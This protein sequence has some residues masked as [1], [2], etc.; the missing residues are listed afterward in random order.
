[1]KT[2]MS[3]IK[4]LILI[5]VLLI[6]EQNLVEAQNIVKPNVTGP[7]GVQVN[8]YN[9]NL[10]YQRQDIFIPGRGLS[11][12]ITFSYNSSCRADD[13]GFGKGWIFNY[14]L[15]YE[16]DS[17]DFILLQMDG[18]RD[19]F[20]AINNNFN[21]PVGV[22]DTLTKYQTSKYQLTTKEGTKYFF[23]NATHKKVSKIEDRYGNTLTFMYSNA[24]LSSITDA[25]GRILTFSWSN[26]HVTSIKNTSITPNRT[27]TYSYDTNDNF[28]KFVDPLGGT[29]KYS[30]D[31]KHK[32]VLI[33]DQNGSPVNIIYNGFTAVKKIAGCETNLSFTYNYTAKKTFVVEKVG[34][35]NQVTTYEYNDNGQVIKQA[36]NCCGYNMIFEYDNS[37][38]ITKIKNGNGNETSYLYDSKGNR[39]KGIDPLGNSVTFTYEPNFNL[40]SSV[41]D[42]RSKTTN[43]TYDINGNITQVTYPLGITES[44]TYNSF[45]YVLTYTD[46]K[47][48]IT[49]Y[50]YDNNGYITS[51]TDVENETTLFTY[52]AVGSVLTINS[53]NGQTT[54]YTYDALD[55]IT[56]LKD[57]LNNTTTYIYDARGNVLSLT[58]ANSNTTLYTYDPLGR[59]LVIEDALGNTQHLDYDSKGNIIQTTDANGITNTYAYDNLN[60]LIFQQNALAEATSFEYDHN[61]N[62]LS[63]ELPNGNVLAMSYDDLDR[64]TDVYDAI[65]AVA[66]YLYDNNSNRIS[67]TDGNGN[68]SYYSYDALNRV[69]TITDP[70][71]NAIT[72]N[73]DNNSNIVSVTD[74]KGNTTTYTYDGLNREVSSTDALNHVITYSYDGI[75]NLLAVNDPNNNATSYTYD[76]LNRRLG[77]SYAD[78]TTVGYTYDA[79]GNLAT[80][81]DNSGQTTSY[82]YDAINRL[83]QRAY[84]DNSTV[85]FT[86]DAGGRM[87]SAINS[88]GTVT[89]NYDLANRLVSET[90]NGKTTGYTYDI[91]SRK[92]TIF[93]PNGR[94]VEEQSDERGRLANITD[95]LTNNLIANY[96][97]DLGNRKTGRSYGNNT[98]ST[99][100]YD[101]NSRLIAIAHNPANF[102]KFEYGYDNND[103]KL[104][105]KKVHRNASSEQYVYDQSDRLIQFKKGTLSGTMV[106]NSTTN[107]QY[108]YDGVGNR[109]SVTTNGIVDNYTANSVNEYTSISGGLTVAFTSDNNGNLISD[110]THNFTYDYENRLLNVDNGNTATYKY[111][112]LGRRIQKIVGTDTTNFYY[113]GVRVIEEQNHF[114]ATIATYVYGNDIDEILTMQGNGNDYFY[115]QNGLGSVSHITN[116]NGLIV[117]QYEYDTYGNVSIYDGNFSVITVSSIDNPYLYTGRRLDSETGLYFYRAR[118]YSSIYGRFLQRDPLGYI[119]GMSMYSYVGGNPQNWIDPLGLNKFPFIQSWGKKFGQLTPYFES[120]FESITSI[121]EAAYDDGYHVNVLSD[122]GMIT[123]NADMVNRVEKLSSLK[124]VKTNVD[125]VKKSTV[126]L[127]ETYKANKASKRIIPNSRTSICDEWNSKKGLVLGLKNM[128]DS[129]LNSSL[130]GIGDYIDK[131]FIGNLNIHFGEMQKRE[132]DRQDVLKEGYR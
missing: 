48:N 23:D 57:A 94:Q 67:E 110:G 50:N 116:S 132:N 24:K 101:A 125:F 16:I 86:Y 85:G 68:T 118:Y 53:P 121:L 32:L 5:F 124:K 55:R 54:T 87:T 117:E 28:I 70:T 97:Y 75:G 13:F 6:I 59:V 9:G 20:T 88:N 103:N 131:I 95:N 120:A 69:K 52:N 122:L 34:T 81:T 91:S 102:A 96:T 90:L 119:D 65:G 21:A 126:V 105:E 38:N 3:N 49:S 15:S 7:L 113:D 14:N 100:S 130:F 62:V 43:Y 73:Y 84:P 11:L 8:T 10:F 74:R 19:I 107:I 111:G 98:F 76:A 114:G 12:D 46:G 72:Y 40:V 26:G 89:L 79:V 2:I 127:Y 41:T 42:R 51:I 31:D 44:Y 30:Y 47:G 78:G 128:I 99:Y 27:Y 80:R 61:G 109:T 123:S 35:S 82:T 64:V 108:N 104:Y 18:S 1:M 112:P 56:S 25:S 33:T 129:P 66:S 92:K 4:H 83:T 115:Y 71:G 37:N 58:D 17:V 29:M 45:G 106:S 93:Y 63:M 36:G 22:F 77:E 39:L 60:R